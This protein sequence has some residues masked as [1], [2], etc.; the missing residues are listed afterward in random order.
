MYVI[1]EEDKPSITLVLADM[2]INCGSKS[3]QVFLMWERIA[4]ADVIP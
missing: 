2:M 1:G 3:S 4:A